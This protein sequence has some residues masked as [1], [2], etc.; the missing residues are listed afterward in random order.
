[1]KRPSLPTVLGASMLLAAAAIALAAIDIHQDRFAL[2]DWA[3]LCDGAAK[4]PRGA[5]PVTLSGE[6]AAHHPV[7]LRLPRRF[8]E[9][10]TPDPDS[11]PPLP[12]YLFLAFALPLDPLPAGTP[13][14][15]VADP[16]IRFAAIGGWRKT[17]LSWLG[18]QVR[19]T[20]G[21]STL[22]PRPLSYVSD[23]TVTGI[24]A[25]TGL[26]KLSYGRSP[27]QG[28]DSYEV[29]VQPDQTPPQSIYWCQKSRPAH[30]RM[31]LEAID[32]LH[33]SMMFDRHRLAQA[34]ALETELRA[35]LR[36]FAGG[37][38]SASR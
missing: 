19:L 33:V 26:A 25:D 36:C 17:G 23:K 15:T 32:G 35:L 30:C 12:G 10:R 24:V 11:D 18:D 6:T 2:P 4:L 31:Y 21:K 38:P 20:I 34:P 27:Y 1:M 14:A 13:R 7:T 9:S 8:I 28:R 5:T 29:F 16:N 22:G 37:T 3:A